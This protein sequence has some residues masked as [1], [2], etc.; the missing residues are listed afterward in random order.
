[1][2][3]R[4][5][6]FGMGGL[7][8]AGMSGPLIRLA[9]VC[10]L[11][12]GFALVLVWRLYTFQIRDVARYQGMATEERRAEIPIIPRRGALLDT[13]GNPLAVSV[14]YESVY[15][16]G[17]LIAD[18]DKTAAALSP[19]LGKPTAEIRA[20]LST[21]SKR[22][23]VLESRVPSAI[24]EQ[25][26][27]VD[28]PGIYLEKEPIREYPEGSLAA[29]LLGFVGR[30]FKGLAG[31][32]L[33]YDAELAGT[34]GLIDSE[35]D[36]AGNEIALSRTVLTPPQEGEDLVLSLDRFVQRTAERLLAE[37]VKKNKA[38]G[39]LIIVMEPRSGNILA[40]ANNPTYSLT[41]DEIYNADKASLY[42]TKIVTDQ[43]EPGSTMKTVTMA[44]AIEEGLISAGTTF[45]DTGVA[46]IGG[47]T[48]KNWNGAANGTITMTQAL[49]L[50]SNVTAQ[51]VAGLLGPDRFYK[52]VDAFGFGAKTGIRLPG[53]VDGMVRTN[54]SSDWSRVDLA[55]NSY[56]QGIAVT[57][58]QMLDAV[59]AFA[60]DGVM[61]KPRL[62]RAVRSERGTEEL[63]AEQGGRAV[64]SRAARTMLQ[65]MVDV[66]RQDAYKPHRIPGYTLALK[67]GTADTPT[68]LG[69]D[70]NRTFASVVSIFPA[71]D[72]RFAVL[73]RLD[74]PEALYG[75]VVALPVLSQL[76]QEMITYYRLP[77]NNAN[78]PRPGN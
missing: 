59:A 1:M 32:E 31:L 45:N 4:E 23:V 62:V 58:L 6:A 42:N 50:S 67:T 73:I 5:A 69:Y 19:I 28:L 71:E 11:F 33:S 77:P 10:A 52:Y 72:P 49:A 44:A 7:G 9:L 3:V 56:G 29:Q 34:P 21:D 20:Q 76:A 24:G 17:S 30:D 61:I 65:M 46:R 53:E 66:G 37:A 18:P 2:A 27:K 39:G 41:A 55:T 54:A 26:R 47:Y 8:R 13:N 78:V 51:W 25:V 16:L 38:S 63:P 48:I 22:P 60:N 74:G 36:T 57:P 64:S 12:A 70:L 14:M 35:R 40:V 68:N 15:A 43:F 75:G